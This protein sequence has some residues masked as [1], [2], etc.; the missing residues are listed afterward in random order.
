MGVVQFFFL[1]FLTFYV[2]LL[3]FELVSIF[4]FF[5]NYFFNGFFFRVR[6]MLYKERAW[7]EL[8]LVFHEKDHTGS[9]GC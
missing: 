5:V 1:F 9:C 2:F 8:I 7:G 3:C 4:V 6:G